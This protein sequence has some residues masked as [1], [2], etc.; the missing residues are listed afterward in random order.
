[1]AMCILFNKKHIMFI[2]SGNLAN[3]H[4]H[5]YCLCYHGN[6]YV[7]KV[8]SQG[9]AFSYV[10]CICVVEDL[11]EVTIEIQYNSRFKIN[12]EHFLQPAP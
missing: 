2:A 6:K 9:N 7:C 10:K 8:K 12:R 5:Y 11:F 4:V 1:M 3:K